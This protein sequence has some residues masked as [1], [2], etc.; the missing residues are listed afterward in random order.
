MQLHFKFV[1]LLVLT[2]PFGNIHAQLLN[3]VVLS[4]IHNEIQSKWE[5]NNLKNLD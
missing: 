3:D 5:W 4:R 2:L 1:I